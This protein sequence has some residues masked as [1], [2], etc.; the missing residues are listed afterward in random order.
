M[1]GVSVSPQGV[2]PLT[3]CN[4]RSLR[5]SGYKDAFTWFPDPKESQDPASL[6]LHLC[7]LTSL[8]FTKFHSCF[9]TTVL[10]SPGPVFTSWCSMA[11][12]FPVP[13]S[14]PLAIV[15]LWETIYK[16]LIAEIKLY[17]DHFPQTTIAPFKLP[18]HAL[19]IWVKNHECSLPDP[20]VQEN[21]RTHTG[22]QVPNTESNSTCWV[23]A[24][25]IQ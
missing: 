8:K 21:R 10:A 9:S 14:Y 18:E 1:P 6:L 25:R 19:Y 22:S 5:T 7:H 15:H 3:L 20:R 24:F 2:T 16:G 13:I 23:G 12:Y 17:A 4:P 11:N